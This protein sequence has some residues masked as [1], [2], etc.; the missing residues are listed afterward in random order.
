MNSKTCYRDLF[1]TAYIALNPAKLLYQ[2]AVLA[3]AGLALLL[4]HSLGDLLEGTLTFISPALRVL[5]WAGFYLIL[6]AGGAPTAAVALRE[7]R[8]EKAL[9]RADARSMGLNSV[10]ALLGSALGPLFF[11][12][13]LAVGLVVLNLLGRIPGAGPVLWAISLFPQFLTGLALAAGLLTLLAGIFLLPAIAADNP[14]VGAA[15]IFRR[16]ISLLKRDF[17]RFWGYFAT[18]VALGGVS[19]ILITGLFLIAVR[20]VGEFTVWA[21]GDAAGA[22]MLSIPELFGNIPSGW[23]AVFVFPAALPPDGWVYPMAGTIAGLSLLAI[24]VL[25]L[26]YPLLYLFNSGTVIYRALNEANRG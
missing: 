2:A 14:G 22:V 4:F 11:T 23:Q 24:H 15:S 5:S 20:L 18:A 9:S 8:G 17:F 10:P 26:S 7:A 16:L 3:A 19:F 21:G 13:V 6:L 12:L 1:R 25:W